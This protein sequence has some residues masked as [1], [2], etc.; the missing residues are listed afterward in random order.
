MQRPPGARRLTDQGRPVGALEALFA[1]L[2]RA[3]DL[4][5]AEERGSSKEAREAAAAVEEAA[6]M[7][8]T[9]FSLGQNAIVLTRSDGVILDANDAFLEL[10]GYTREDLE[11][12]RIRWHEL[13]PKEYWHL[14]EAGR[15]QVRETGRC[16]P[17][18]KEY[19]KKDGTRAPILIGAASVEPRRDAGIAFIVDLSEQRK[20]EQALRETSALLEAIIDASPAG[21]IVVDLEEKVRV[22]NAA[23]E[24][25]F[26]FTAEE[27]LGQRYPYASTLGV[28]ELIERLL[29]GESVELPRTKG[30]RKDGTEV[31]ISLYLSPLPD[32]SGK[33]VG[34]VG[35]VLDLT[36]QR[37]LE[38]QLLHA[39]KLEAIG[40]LAGGIAHDFNNTLSVIVGFAEML[41]EQLA[42]KD[43]LQEHCA[44]IARAAERATSLTRQLLAFGRKQVLRLEVMS[45]ADVIRRLERVLARVL[46]ADVELQVRLPS[47]LGLIRADPAQVEQVLLNLVVNARDA[48][49]E[50]GTLTLEAADVEL[51][52]GYA[53]QN[54]DVEPGPYVMIAVR[55][56]GHGMTPETRARIFEPFF[57]TKEAGKG[58]GLGLSTVYGIIKQSGG[59]VEVESAP[60]EGACFRVYFP[61]TGEA[62]PKE[63]APPA[64]VTARG[65]ETV[66]VV[67]DEEMVRRLVARVL[68]DRGFLVLEA[69][70]CDEALEVCARHEGPI[71]LLLTDVVMPRMSGV[72]LARR[73]SQL[74]PEMRVLYMSGYV[75]AF[76]PGSPPLG[77]LLEKPFTPDAL[78]QRVRQTLG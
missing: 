39:Q 11:E 46:G 69:K 28:P 58:T 77:A 47:D 8:R 66:L 38:E 10:V 1:R 14:E 76:A 2:S 26:G 50:G 12:G 32:E 37:R 52:E 63:A 15:R 19:M 56:T 48:M 65:S 27:V 68:G 55:D 30:P 51:D 7:L 42:E 31:D 33:I 25:I 6:A 57:T 49:P 61:R 21:I 62:R 73:L 71:H 54:V 23:A 9:F 35:L 24:R 3:R 59:H 74:R 16:L 5:L 64:R 60:G 43:P 29:R 17:F 75:D 4:L 40:R 18:E 72:E 45:P 67:E 36:E 13:T 34:A 44:Q 20:A 78:L 41:R 70:R 53:R 22:W